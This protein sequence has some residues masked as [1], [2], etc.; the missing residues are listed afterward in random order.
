MIPRR[1]A[2]R[3]LGVMKRGLWAMA[4]QIRGIIQIAKLGDEIQVDC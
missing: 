1:I 2:K 4:N 3:K